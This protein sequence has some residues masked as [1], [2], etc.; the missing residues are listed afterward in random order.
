MLKLINVLKKRNAHHR[1]QYLKFD[2]PTHK[3]THTKDINSEYISV[4][5]WIHSHFPEFNS[6]EI[7]DKMMKGKNWNENNKYW[8]LTKEEIKNQWKENADSVSS[9]GTEMHF[10]IECFMNNNILQGN[11]SHEDLNEFYISRDYKDETKEWQYFLNFVRDYPELVPYRTE[12][13]V[14]DQHL[15]LAGSIDMLYKNKDGTLSIYDWKRAK[16]IT[17][18]NNFN[19]F[20]IAECIKHLP[21]TNFWHYAL[22]LNIYK[23]ILETNYKILIKDLYLVRLH[24]DAENYELIKLPI[25]TKEINDMFKEKQLKNKNKCLIYF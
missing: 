20:A 6:D 25:L 15:K 13:A 21:D 18:K 5:T 8:G 22:Q 23:A 1:D 10:K 19:K 11:Y 17:K 7:I 14:F 16:E 2:E 24:P 3:Y 9:L 4:T 12:W